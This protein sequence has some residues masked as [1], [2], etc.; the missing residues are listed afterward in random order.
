MGGCSAEYSIASLKETWA[1]LQEREA[2]FP[3]GFEMGLIPGNDRTLLVVSLS[4]SALCAS[5]P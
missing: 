5:N 1:W 3:V 2:N 4:L